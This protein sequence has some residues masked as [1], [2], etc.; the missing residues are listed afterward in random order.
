[1][2]KASCGVSADLFPHA[3]EPDF[4]WN[5][6]SWV[7]WVKTTTSQPNSPINNRVW[8]VGG[9]DQSWNTASF[10]TNFLLFFHC[11]CLRLLSAVVFSIGWK[12]GV[13]HSGVFA[14]R[15][16]HSPFEFSFFSW[17]F[18]QREWWFWEKIVAVSSHIFPIVFMHVFSLS[19]SSTSALFTYTHEQ[20][21]DAIF[22]QSFCHEE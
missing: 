3:H 5:S 22:S 14:W 13:V 16:W 8:G 21:V 15:V 11:D 17:L 12:R 9:R 20:V 19:F 7:I 1:M 10:I 6:E 4:W 18:C 2:R